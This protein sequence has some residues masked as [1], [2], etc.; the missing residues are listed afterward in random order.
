MSCSV[1][2]ISARPLTEEETRLLTKGLNF[3][4]IK[5]FNPFGTILD[6]NKFSR[7]LTLRK[8]YFLSVDDD[9]APPRHL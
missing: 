5:H 9:K 3:C 8:H 7:A 4:P 1:M 2:N 6:V